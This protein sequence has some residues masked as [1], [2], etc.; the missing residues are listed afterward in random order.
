MSGGFEAAQT[1][2]GFVYG[3]DVGVRAG[4]GLEGALG[5]AGDG[6]VFLQIGLTADAPSTNNFADSGF[7]SALKG[8]LGAAIPSR[9]GLSGRIRMPYTLRAPPSCR[10][11]T[12]LTRNATRRSPSPP[13]T[14]VCWDG[15]PAGR[16]GSV[17]FSSCSGASSASWHTDCLGSTVNR[18][19]RPPD[20]LGRIINYKSIYFELPIVEYRPYRA[21]LPTRA[22]R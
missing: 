19:E 20:G 16:R 9:T 6:L 17:A 1:Q 18:A 15:K 11:C 10:L 5:D 2:N 12:S 22:R 21:F 3:L 8:S 4:L 13:P 14:A 7:G